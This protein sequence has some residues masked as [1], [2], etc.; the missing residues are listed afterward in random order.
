[1]SLNGCRF[2]CELT[3]MVLENDQD[4]LQVRL[5]HDFTELI[6]AVF[7]HFQDFNHTIFKDMFNLIQDILQPSSR[8]SSHIPSRQ[9]STIKS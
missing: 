6:L 5:G 7:D 3:E 4:G 2:T 8:Q 1:M 9:S